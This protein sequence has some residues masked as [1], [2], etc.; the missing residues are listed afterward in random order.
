MVTAGSP[1]DSGFLT[2]WQPQ[3]SRLLAW[4]LGSPKTGVPGEVP[5]LS[6]PGHEIQSITSTI[7]CWLKQSST[8]P[9]YKDRVP[10]SHLIVGEA[11]RNLQP[12]FKTAA[13][14]FQSFFFFKFIYLVSCFWLHWVFIVVP[15]LSLVVVSGGYSWLR[16][17][18]FS[19][20]WLLLWQRTGSRHLG[21]SSCSMWVQ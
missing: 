21:F 15:G 16:C 7:F 6:C 9:R 14:Y 17:T 2:A 8:H 20:Q 13:G 11:L 12:C 18:N 3:G 4:Y 5:V 1:Y 19:L 10:I